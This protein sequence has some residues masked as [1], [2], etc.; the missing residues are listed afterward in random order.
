MTPRNAILGRI[1]A[2]LRAPAPRPAAPALATIFPPLRAEELPSRFEREFAALKGVFHRATDRADARAW[3]AG[4]AARRGWKDLALSPDADV[5]DLAGGLPGARP[6]DAGD[7]GARLGSADVGI[8]PCDCLV[9]RTGSVAL[10]AQ[11]GF[12]RALSV[13]PPAHLVVARPAQLVA[14]V[15]DALQF[16]ERRHGAMWPSMVTFITGPSRTADIEKILVLGAHGP[17]ELYVLLLDA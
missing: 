4:L 16:L 5:L 11:S 2:A 6:L 7:C 12:G 13:L 9:A 1:R 3:I 10:T 15:R 14:E 17:R 8:T